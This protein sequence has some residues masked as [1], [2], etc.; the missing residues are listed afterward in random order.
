L[1][2]ERADPATVKGWYLG[3][4][5]SDL[6]IS[7]GYAP[8]GIDEPHIHTRIT[9]IYLVARGTSK[10]RVGEQTVTLTA[11]DVVVVE[12]GEPHTFVSSSPDYF[13]FVIHTPG[14]EGQAARDER[15]AI[16]HAE[17]GL[18]PKGS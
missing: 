14:L 1:R 9:E 17:L 6:P 2:I 8:K 4:W 3:P 7:L 11:G 16:T 12:P 18:Q 5:N 15:V 13:H 10:I